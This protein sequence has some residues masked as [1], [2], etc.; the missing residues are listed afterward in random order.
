M[1][2]TNIQL[3]R[4][5]RKIT[6]DDLA[7]SLGIERSTVSNWETE[8][9]MPRADLLPKLAEVL[10]CSIDDLFRPNGLMDTDAS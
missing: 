3:M 9:A 10:G 4:E 5:Y 7:K 6:Q 1:V 2:S 8:K